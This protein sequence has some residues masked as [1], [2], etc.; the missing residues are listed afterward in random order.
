MEKQT[1]GV[2]FVTT[3]I[4]YFCILHNCTAS[5]FHYSKN[6]NKQ[7]TSWVSSAVK[8]KE[9]WPH[10][11]SRTTTRVVLVLNLLPLSESSATPL[12]YFLSLPLTPHA[13]L[14]I[15]ARQCTPFT[16]DHAAN[17]SIRVFHS[18]AELVQ[19][20][21]RQKKKHRESSGARRIHVEERTL[22]QKDSQEKKK[23]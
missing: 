22:R 2:A 17:H 18:P 4:A 6:K 21:S 11:V 12:T 14:Y 16:L 8:T 23:E 5:T 13:R 7:Q 1:T 10:V 15:P 20:H 9:I 3:A 19:L